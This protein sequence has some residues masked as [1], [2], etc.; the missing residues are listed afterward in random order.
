LLT[1]CGSEFPGV[2]SLRKECGDNQRAAPFF[3]RSAPP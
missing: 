2:A 1:G 3:C